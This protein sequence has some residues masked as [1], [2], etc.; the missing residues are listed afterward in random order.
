MDAFLANQAD[1]GQAGFFK[2]L[3]QKIKMALRKCG[4]NAKWTDNEIKTLLRR[5]LAK[6]QRDRKSNAAN[7]DIRYAAAL[8]KLGDPNNAEE[9]NKLIDGR[10]PHING[11][12]DWAGLKGK[13][14][15]ADYEFLYSRHSQ[16]FNSPEEAKAAVEL[17]LAMP[18][19]VKSRDKNISFVGFDEVTGDI[20]RIEINPVVTGRS[21]HIRSVFKITANQYN[22]IKLD[23]PRVLQPSKTALHNGR[24]ATMTISNFMDNKSQNPEN[25]SENQKKL[26]FSLKNGENAPVLEV[27]W[28]KEGS[29]HPKDY[30]DVEP[31]YWVGEEGTLESY[32]NELEGIDDKKNNALKDTLNAEDYN[33]QRFDDIFDEEWQEMSE[34]ER[35][36]HIEGSYEDR[37]NELYRE[38]EELKETA[39]WRGRD[40]ADKK[41]EADYEYWWKSKQLLIPARDMARAYAESLGYTIIEEDENSSGTSYYLKVNNGED[42]MTLRFSDHEQP[43]YKWN[44]E[45]VTYMRDGKRYTAHTD[46]EVVIRD[47]KLDLAPIWEFL[48]EFAPEGSEDTDNG[49]RYSI[50]PQTDTPQFK[51]WFKDSKVV[52]ENGEPLVVYHGTN[53]DFNIF[54]TEKFGAWDNGSKFD[55]KGVDSAGKLIMK[56][57]KDEG[58]F[59]ST[60]KQNAEAHAEGAT[61]MGGGL[62]RIISAYLRA[63]K[64]LIVEIDKFYAETK[65]YDTQ[66]WYDH[67]TAAILNNLHSGDYDSIIIKNPTNKNDSMYI[68]FSP[69]QIKSAT[70]NIGTFDPNNPDIRYLKDYDPNEPFVPDSDKERMITVLLGVDKNLLS[71]W[72]YT[73][74]KEYLESKLF[75]LDDNTAQSVLNAARTKQRQELQKQSVRKLQRERQT[76]A[77]EAY[78]FYRI[79]T[80]LFGDDLKGKII[81]TERQ[82]GIEMSGSFIHPWFKHEPEWQKKHAADRPKGNTDEIAQR[83]SNELGRDVDENEIIEFFNGFTIAQINSD[84]SKLKAT[85]KEEDAYFTRIAQEEWDSLYRRSCS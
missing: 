24:A 5:S 70:D 29:P 85:Q 77:M 26:R 27:D 40:L 46:I 28:E 74:A 56:P 8:R 22:E 25:A 14:L 16:Y 75:E 81:P 43:D 51:N 78:P 48:E 9:K 30:D 63:E 32:R 37:E 42:D 54:D 31:I 57:I 72:D 52:D 67:N 45:R 15:Y 20:Y 2:S 79:A 61:D 21:N 55:I 6:Q 12:M 38:I 53:A 34:D 39:D 13:N 65:H 80:E 59:F 68:V 49:V 71:D 4:F 50:A 23:M 62:P 33:G 19:Q 76:Y 10:V 17:V 73:T 69:N 84:Y 7:G 83:A 47:F 1:L 58:F 66:D 44:G 3:V 36:E 18:E 82:K 35:I 11:F 64:P 60:K 41:I